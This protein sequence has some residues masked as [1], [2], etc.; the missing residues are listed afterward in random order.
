MSIKDSG[1]VEC[2]LAGD[3]HTSKDRIAFISKCQAVKDG[4]T[5]WFRNADS[6]PPINTMSYPRRPEY[7]E[8]RCENL[9]RRNL[10][11]VYEPNN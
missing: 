6:H 1:P 10:I 11:N 7:C 4:G 3:S 9:V 2:C 8:Y 5:A